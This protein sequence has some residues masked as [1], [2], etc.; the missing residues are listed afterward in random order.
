MYS[1]KSGRDRARATADGR[2]AGR[3]A[4][5]IRLAFVGL[6]AAGVAVACGPAEGGGPAVPPPTLA[7]VSPT[8]TPSP[9]AS[10]TPTATATPTALPSPSATTAA[11]DAKA[12]DTPAPT[13]AATQPAPKPTTKAP[14]TAPEEPA[15]P[16]KA[17]CEI[18][19]NAGN[20]YNA[21]QFCRK[22]DVGRSTHAG[23]GRMISCRQ[24]GGQP[25]WGY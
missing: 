19:S 5:R 6:L 11:P 3:R 18:V 9:T 1:A 21:G 17:D 22:A 4:G 12:P 23:N 2:G 15:K 7:S 13:R 14:T 20:C 16:V 8:A 24:D 25:R 10:P